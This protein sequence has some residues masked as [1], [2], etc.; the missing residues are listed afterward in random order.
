MRGGSGLDGPGGPAT[1]TSVEA[2]IAR[3]LLWGGLVSGLFVLLGLTLYAAGGGVSAR[4]L[5]LHRLGRPERLA[6]PPDVFVSLGEVFRGLSA[7]PLDP[8]AVTALGL[9]LLLMTPALGVAVA[10]PAFVR[11]GDRRYAAIAG[12]VLAMLLVSLLLAGGV[13]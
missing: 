6:H 5:E 9:V 10:I 11:A 8:L 2:L 13:A 7:R 3:V 12:I 1:G 4:V